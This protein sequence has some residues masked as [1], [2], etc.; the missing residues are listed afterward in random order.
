NRVPRLVVRA[1]RV[2]PGMEARWNDV[3]VDA[4]AFETFIP[5]DPGTYTVAVSA[6]GYVEF[7]ATIELA[8]SESKTLEVPELRAAPARPSPPPVP[9]QSALVPLRQPPQRSDAEP[10][11]AARRWPGYLVGGAGIAALGV[12]AFF[13]VSSLNAYDEAEQECPSHEGCTAEVRD[14][15]NEAETKAWVANLTL[16]AGLLAVGIGAWLVLDAS[17]EPQTTVFV[18]V[19]PNARGAELRLGAS[20]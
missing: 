4:A 19:T 7:T 2:L 3:R 15:R 18:H 20:L 11:E 8:E 12:G 6:P 14:L 17:D 9:P 16:G 5:L 1:A 13:G 10:V